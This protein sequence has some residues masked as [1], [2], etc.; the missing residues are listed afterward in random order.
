MKSQFLQDNELIHMYMFRQDFVY[1][2]ELT[3]FQGSHL[4]IFYYHS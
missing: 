3:Q 4:L 1:I 2:L